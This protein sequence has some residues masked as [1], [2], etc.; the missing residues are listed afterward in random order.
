MTLADCLCQI[1]DQAVEGRRPS[2]EDMNRLLGALL[3]DAVDAAAFVGVARET[4]SLIAGVTRAGKDAWPSFFNQRSDRLFRLLLG[5]EAMLPGETICLRQ[6]AAEG[7]APSCLFLTVFALSPCSAGQRV[8]LCLWS[9][10]RLESLADGISMRL[11]A[12]ILAAVFSR[13]PGIEP[14]APPARSKGF[15]PSVFAHAPFGVA[16]LNANGATIYLNDAYFSLFGAEQPLEEILGQPFASRPEI[17]SLSLE[18]ELQALREGRGFAVERS[19]TT[20]KGDAATARFTGAILETPEEEGKSAA[21][22]AKSEAGK[23]GG[24]SKAADG[25]ARFILY[26]QDLTGERKLGD[27]YSN[28]E[29]A[30]LASNDG[31]AIAS[32]EG[33]LVFTNRAFARIFGHAPNSLSQTNYWISL[34]A[35]ASQARIE[36]ECKQQAWRAGVWTGELQSVRAD[37]SERPVELT[38]TAIHDADGNPEGLILNCRDITRRRRLEEEL[39]HAQKMEGIG[40]LAGGIA[41]DFNNLLTG[42]LGFAE[43]LKSTIGPAPISRRYLENIEKSALQAAELTRKLLAF[44]RRRE[45]RLGAQDINKMVAGLIPELRRSLPS[46]VRIMD[47]FWRDALWA[48]VDIPSLEQALRNLAQ[49]SVEAME[50][51]SGKITLRTYPS[52]DPN[53]PPPD[54]H[55]A[56][57]REPSVAIVVED[58]GCG[59]PPEILQRAFDPFVSTKEVGRGSGLGLAAVYGI[60]KAHHGAVHIE[61]QVGVGTAVYIYLPL[62]PAAEADL[63]RPL[64]QP[65]PETFEKEPAR[66]LP[67][68]KA[69]TILVV[70]DEEMLRNLIREILTGSG[71]QVIVCASGDEALQAYSQNSDEIDLVLTDFAMAEMN[72]RELSTALHSLNPSVRTILSSGYQP[73]GLDD[74]SLDP[75]ALKQEGVRAFL[76]KP[77]SPAELVQIVRRTLDEE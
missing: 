37:G 33:R 53:M 58:Q 8:F 26:I 38:M 70:D 59:I 22:A 72:G 32:R 23:A 68:A 76:P 20:R 16:I 36:A 63:A 31:F 41:H 28:L 74:G 60:V 3:S 67:R 39:V 47:E 6:T 66:R 52:N 1:S 35:P 19:F 14:A 64:T 45:L 18:E 10:V 7:D 56:L 2:A 24:G 4:P 12:A 30:V 54:S 21:P 77:Y 5:I 73:D 46:G 34:F 43:M 27:S 25:E 11:L 61:S 65:R 17:Q 55:P 13:G 51:R 29:M 9:S 62:A 40:V 75:D 44:G 57:S 48:A 50:G 71:Y 15:S 49:N 42:I 69:E